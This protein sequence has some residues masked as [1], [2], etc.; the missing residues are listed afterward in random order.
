MVS[1]EAPQAPK[2]APSPKGSMRQGP[3]RQL[4]QQVPNSPKP[5]CGVWTAKRSQMVLKSWRS[6]TF[7]MALE[8]ES[9][10]FS[11][12]LFLSEILILEGLKEKNPHRYLDYL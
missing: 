6:A 12:R 7:S 11:I 8:A 2:V 1:A 5:H 10:V 3:C 4:R 9:V